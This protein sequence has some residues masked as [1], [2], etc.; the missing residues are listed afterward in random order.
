MLFAWLPDLLLDLAVFAFIA[1]GTAL[2][3]MVRVMVEEGLNKDNV[4]EHPRDAG[5]VKGQSDE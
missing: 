4:I 2:C 3:V 5:I 1:S